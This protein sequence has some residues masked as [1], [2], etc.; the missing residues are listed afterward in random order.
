V[1]NFLHTGCYR[2]CGKANRFEETAAG[3]WLCIANQRRN[4][5][6]ALNDLFMDL[7]D[8]L[9]AIDDEIALGIFRCD[10]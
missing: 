10:L 4:F 8:G 5:C 9:G 1:W 3:I 6:D 7:I 2:T